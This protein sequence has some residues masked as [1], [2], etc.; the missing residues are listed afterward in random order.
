MRAG[1]SKDNRFM[2]TILYRVLEHPRYLD[3]VQYGYPRR[4]H[5][6]GTIA[7]HIIQLMVN[8][9]ILRAAGRV[10]PEEYDKLAILAHSHDTFKGETAAKGKKNCAI[11][12]PDSHAS[13]ARAFLAELG[14]DQD[15]LAIAQYHDLGYALYRN[16]LSTGKVNE[17]RLRDGI[18]QIKD[19]DLF[20]KFCLIDTC[21]PSK[22]REGIAWWIDEV[23]ARRE[24]TVT[25]EWLD[26]FPAPVGLEAG[27]F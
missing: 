21:T 8:L 10:T 9:D 27:V 11:E 1:S 16:K 4:G 7:A 22:G 15:L 5:D 6:E 23:G 20:L 3:G 17:N 18:N 14:A 2:N 26:L 25:R 24:T 12:D 13:L 19:C